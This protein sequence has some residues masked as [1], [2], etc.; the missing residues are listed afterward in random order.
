MQSSADPVTWTVDVDKI[1]KGQVAD[2]QDVQSSRDSASCGYDFVVGKRYRVFANR[3]ENGKL[4]TGLCSGTAE[5]SAPPPT[6]TV[7]ATTTTSRAPRPTTTSTA[8]ASTT[9]TT[10]A[11]TTTSTTTAFAIRP[12]SDNDN[13][14]GGGRGGLAVI[15]ALGVLATGAGALLIRR[16]R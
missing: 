4:A 6:S 8:I 12:A 5:Q 13:D 16:F 15:A 7:V 2:P 9:T 1:E 11:P 14:N 3:Q 10:S